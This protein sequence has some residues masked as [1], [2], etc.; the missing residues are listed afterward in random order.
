MH[1]DY[2]HIIDLLDN[3]QPPYSFIYSLFENKLS[4]FR[5]YI[6]KN[7]ANRFIKLSK[8]SVNISILFVF[9]PNR[10]LQL[11]VDY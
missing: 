6:N 3:K 2:N 8:S 9:K 10:D 4:I 1:E 5:T 7:L 11:C